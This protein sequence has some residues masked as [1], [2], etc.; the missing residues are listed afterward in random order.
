[1]PEMSQLQQLVAIAENGTISQAAEQLQ[2]S[3]PSLTRSIQR[4][5]SEWGVTLFDR[6]KNK[7]TLNRTGK[8]AVQYA[9]QVL[10]EV[11]NMTAAVKCFE[12][13]LHTISVGSCTP[14]PIMA[15]HPLLLERFSILSEEKPQ[16]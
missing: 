14:G 11:D 15:L 12:R 2:L 1:M 4:L 7:V 6:K 9:R 13:S 3:Q 8:L 10:N 16:E 5:E